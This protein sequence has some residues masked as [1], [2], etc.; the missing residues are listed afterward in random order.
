[1]ISKNESNFEYNTSKMRKYWCHNCNTFFNKVYIEAYPLE[2]TLCQSPICEEITNNTDIS[3]P[4]DFIP[5]CNRREADDHRITVS[6]NSPFGN[7]IIDLINSGYS[8]REIE[9]IVNDIIQNEILSHGTPPASKQAVESLTKYKFTK[10]NITVLGTENCCSVC[11]DEFNEGDEAMKL[12]CNH[13]FHI[14]C[15]VPWFSEHNSCP[16]CRFE[17]P[18]DDE[19]YEKMKREKGGEEQNNR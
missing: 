2:C 19:E 11:K 13:F 5:Y 7:L 4:Q 3:P 10:D 18:T 16:V 6:R 14:D 15:I 8:N 1:M 12:P 17:L 9:I